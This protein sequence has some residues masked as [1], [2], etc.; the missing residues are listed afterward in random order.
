MSTSF[1]DRPG[2]VGRGDVAPGDD[3]AP[4]DIPHAIRG[5]LAG[6]ALAR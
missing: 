2:N 6:L 5:Y 1:S 3:L 4:A